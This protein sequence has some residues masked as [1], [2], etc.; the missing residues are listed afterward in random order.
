MN[1]ETEIKETQEAVDNAWRLCRTPGD[2]DRLNNA[3]RIL[4]KIK[5]SEGLTGRL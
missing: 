3:Q 1:I 4:D 5:D 2:I